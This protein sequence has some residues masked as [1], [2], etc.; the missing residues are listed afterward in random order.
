LNA[1]NFF[2]RQQAGST[3]CGPFIKNRLF[4]FAGSGITNPNFGKIT[5]TD[6]DPRILQMALKVAW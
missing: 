1:T 2:S 3:L 6:G 5:N 4:G